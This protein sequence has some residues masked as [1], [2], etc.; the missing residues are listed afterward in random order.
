[1]STQSNGVSWK[2]GSALPL[3]LAAA[4]GGACS[5][6]GAA[7][8][9]RIETETS[10]LLLVHRDAGATAWIS[11]PVAGKNAF[12]LDVAERHELVIVCEQT[13]ARRQI[14]VTQY[15]RTTDDGDELSGL[16]PN[17]P[18]VV[19]GTVMQ[20]GA[21][22]F[23]GALTISTSTSWQISLPAKAGT[24]DLF[25]FGATGGFNLRTFGARR[26][27]E[28]TGDL[29]L[30]VID[31]ALEATQPLVAT[32]FAAGDLR[33][34]EAPYATP[35]LITDDADLLI[36]GASDDWTAFLLPEAALVGAERQLVELS[37]ASSQTQGGVHLDLT[38]TFVASS[39]QT[40]PVTL[41]ELIGAPVLTHQ[42][43]RSI[44]TWTTLPDYDQ[45][46]FSRFT[47]AADRSR[48]LHEL[49]MSRSYAEATSATQL[50]LDFREIPGLLPEWEL[51]A[52]L[53]PGFDLSA[54]QGSR[55]QEGSTFSSAG[56][57]FSPAAT[58]R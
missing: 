2:A 18:F 58:A 42:A 44:A 15:A 4:A 38:R 19:R 28:V 35:R 3:L 26:G 5:S 11:V 14:T 50:E 12:E 9:L 46:V 1:M 33:P 17:R 36:V 48:K 47:S 29:N 40:S 45:L 10:P 6:D 22:A 43:P 30:G 13:G 54:H 32:T 37:A 51:A 24:S 23:D 31:L 27:V 53:E 21:V 52:G 20:P 55:S 56:R 41:P 16:C 8:G 7:S 49:R 34:D 57:Q 39:T 25:L